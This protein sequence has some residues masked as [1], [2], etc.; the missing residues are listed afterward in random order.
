MTTCYTESLEIEKKKRQVLDD[1]DYLIDKTCCNK[2]T[3]EN[4][5]RDLEKLQHEC[6][7]AFRDINYLHSEVDDKGLTEGT[8]C[9]ILKNKKNTI[10]D[11]LNNTV[12]RK[13]RSIR[14]GG[15]K[16]N[17]SSKKRKGKS[18]SSKRRQ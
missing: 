12:K 6:D 18:K 2:E 3:C 5:S 7:D 9:E 11:K 14:R 1:Y 13:G 17:K 15:K 16:V 10:L 4:Y 8:I